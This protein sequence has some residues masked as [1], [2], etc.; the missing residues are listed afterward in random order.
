MKDLISSLCRWITSPVLPVTRLWTKISS[1]PGLRADSSM[2]VAWQPRE[3]TQWRHLGRSQWSQIIVAYGGNGN[4]LGAT[5]CMSTIT[6]SLLCDVDIVFQLEVDGSREWL[7]ISD[8]ARCCKMFETHSAS[9][10]AIFIATISS[11]WP[12]S[13]WLF[14]L[15]PVYWI[16][17]CHLAI[18][19]AGRVAAAGMPLSFFIAWICLSSWN[20]SRTKCGL[21]P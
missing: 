16:L 12:S 7:N 19:R 3:V 1:S 10:T 13:L 5:S 6:A 8:V 21:H 17:G 18:G 20:V 15:Y 4:D 14:L 11:C 9:F 2:R